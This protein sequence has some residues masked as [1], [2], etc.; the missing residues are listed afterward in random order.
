M[1]FRIFRLVPYLFSFS[2]AACF[3]DLRTLHH[4]TR[5][6]ERRTLAGG[7]SPW[8]SSR[9]SPEM[10]LSLG[11]GSGTRMLLT[12]AARGAGGGSL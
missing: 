8:S 10:L 4:L 3:Q 5:W 6:F 11:A 7:P 9:S 1:S 2:A 12:P